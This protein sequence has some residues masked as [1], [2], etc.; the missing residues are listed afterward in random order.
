MDALSEREITWGSDPQGREWKA[1]QRAGM[2]Q[3]NR[4][5]EPRLEGGGVQS[6]GGEGTGHRQC[7]LGRLNEINIDNK[8]DREKAQ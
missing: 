6:G 7:M 4:W 2:R 1:I 3:P 8:C 5:G